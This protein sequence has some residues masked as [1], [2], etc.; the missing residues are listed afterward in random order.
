VEANAVRCRLMMKLVAIGEHRAILRKED[1]ATGGYRI[2]PRGVTSVRDRAARY[3]SAGFY[4]PIAYVRHLQ[5]CD[6]VLTFSSVDSTA[7]HARQCCSI[8]PALTLVGPP[9]PAAYQ[10]ADPALYTPLPPRSSHHPHTHPHR[11]THGDGQ[12]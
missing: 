7:P 1:A 11:T 8:A 10:G 4:E 2:C 9:P 5:R 3:K 6:Q 12:G